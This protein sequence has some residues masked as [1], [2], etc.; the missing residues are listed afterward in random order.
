MAEVA[1][2]ALIANNSNT[3]SNITIANIERV[4]IQGDL[5]QLSESDRVAY[6]TQVCESL[7]LNPLTQ[8]FSYIRLN[9]KLKLYALREATE[10]LR[11]IHSVSVRITS[12][13]LV[14][15][16]VYVVTA[17]ASMPDG[18]CDES[19]GAVFIGGL[20]GDILANCFMKAESKAKRRVT[21]SICGLA[22]LDESEVETISEQVA[23]PESEIWRQWRSPEDAINW[24]ISQLPEIDPEVVRLK[25]E[26]LPAVNGKKAPAWADH[27]RFLQAR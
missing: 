8:P 3:M 10:Q 1:A 26:E 25:F 6:Y 14:A 9:G 21:L 22:L 12:R 2:S 11:R 4:L 13:E 24:G 20:Q 15:E 27:V 16:S 5:S 17:Q 7:G 19:I 23:L 18:R